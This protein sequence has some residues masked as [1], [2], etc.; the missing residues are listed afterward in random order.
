[1][2]PRG[3]LAAAEFLFQLGV[4]EQDGGGATVRTGAAQRRFAQSPQQRLH[5]RL[6]EGVARAHG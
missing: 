3:D 1:M 6:G 5:L 2:A 4:A